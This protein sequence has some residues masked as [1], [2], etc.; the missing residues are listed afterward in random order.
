MTSKKPI[1]NSREV[2]IEWLGPNGVG[3]AVAGKHT[4]LIPGTL[5]GDTVAW[6]AT[7]RRGRSIMGT[8]SHTLTASPLRRTP[9]CP[10]SDACGGCDLAH[11]LPNGRHTWLPPIAQRALRYASLPHW[12]PSPRE[13][14]HRARVKLAVAGKTIGYRT[15][16]SHEIV[17]V[18]GCGI[19]R[20][21][22]E[23]GLQ[24]LH[25]LL[26][27]GYSLPCKEVEIRSDGTRISFD[28][29]GPKG[30]PP[31]IGE[32]LALLGS[33]SWNGRAIAG[34]P[35]LQ[36]PVGPIELQVS[37]GVFYQVNLEIN[38]LLVAHVMQIVES[39]VPQRVLDF[40]SGMGN[41]GLQIAHKG[42]P[43]LC[44]EQPGRA[45]D[46]CRAT[47][48]RYD[49]TERMEILALP[50]RRFEPSRSF[51]DVAVVDPPRAGTNG[52]LE[53]LLINRPRHIVYVSCHIGSGSA[54]I[55]KALKAGYR[56]VDVTCF[57]MFPD[58]H[59]F[60]T[61]IHLTRE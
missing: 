46:D 53:R 49:L 7:E 61:V 4:V 47:A 22:V 40:Y 21:E 43:V 1:D 23:A 54:D 17:P 35:T 15:R 3:G 9:P 32:T 59:H 51:F 56:I 5:P 30:V 25:K 6:E 31:E 18:K 58:T 10:D 34:S 14:G 48:Q 60:E 42:I 57:D 28:F 45:I 2:T 24:S 44:V 38:A 36:L 50:D 41:F 52:S 55:R 13:R 33:A 16:R 11:M 8:V 12:I 29:I 39:V 37:P 20:P 27:S 19:A 26:D